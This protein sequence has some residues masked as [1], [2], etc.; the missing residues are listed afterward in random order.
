MT[1]ELKYIN[2]VIIII[3][4]GSSNW[5]GGRQRLNCV[6]RRSKSGRKLGDRGTSSSVVI[7]TELPDRTSWGS[8]SGG[9]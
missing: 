9:D 6:G 7:A 8:N 4:S 1:T 5:C 2:F 3:I